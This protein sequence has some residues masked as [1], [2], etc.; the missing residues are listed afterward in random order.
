[1]ELYVLSVELPT[2]YYRTLPEAS[3]KCRVVDEDALFALIANGKE[4]RG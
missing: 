3:A 4:G 1:M 2:A